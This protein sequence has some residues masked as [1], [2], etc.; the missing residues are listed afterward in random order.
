M[1]LGYAR[2][3]LPA[4]LILAL[5][6]GHG[7]PFAVP[8]EG[9]GQPLVPGVPTRL[10]YNPLLDSEIAW[11]A[12]GAALL[13]TA[14]RADEPNLS[15][16]IEM[17]PP[18]GGRSI[19]SLCP[20]PAIRDSTVALES[21]ALS[22]SGQLAYLRS[23]KSPLNSGW[24]QRS[25]VML[26]RDGRLR[27]VAAAPFADPVQPYFGASQLRWLDENRFVYLGEAYQVTF[28]L[29]CTPYDSATPLFIVTVDLTTDPAIVTKV[30]GTNGATGVSVLGPDSILFT[31]GGDAH[32]YRQVL[33]TGVV[34]SVWD[35]GAG[36]SVYWAQRS[37]ARLT[38]LVDGMPWLVDL[39][40]ATSAPIANPGNLRYQ[41]LALSPD[42]RRLAATRAGDLWLFD[43][44]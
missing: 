12:D 33:S 38:A 25:L 43:L 39:G 24:I 3:L 14:T 18:A 2:R 15:R 20:T 44:P 10:T 16:C 29:G 19:R 1:I 35:F 9:T 26:S 7:E 22:D 36:R 28:C 21:A 27:E 23:A 37:G 42:G 6:C 11:S 31:L 8:I 32:V 4:A 17:L 5:A 34:S 30:A 41:S 13:Y 40:A